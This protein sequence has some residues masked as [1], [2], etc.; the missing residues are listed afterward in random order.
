MVQARAAKRSGISPRRVEDRKRRRRGWASSP[1][2]KRRSQRLFAVRRAYSKDG[3]AILNCLASAFAPYRNSY[4]PAAFMDTVLDP[5][6]VQDR[7]REISVFVAVSKEGV[8]VG[9]LALKASG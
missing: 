1:P 5:E 2:A 6:L 7:L 4:T 9:T 8:V 3:E